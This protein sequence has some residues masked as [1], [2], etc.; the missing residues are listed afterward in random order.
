DVE[1]EDAQMRHEGDGEE[2]Q[3]KEEVEGLRAEATGKRELEADAVDVADGCQSTTEPREPAAD[4]TDHPVAQRVQQLL[5]ADVLDLVAAQLAQR[6]PDGG[7]LLRL[8]H[9][10]VHGQKDGQENGEDR[11]QQHQMSISIVFFIQ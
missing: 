2:P 5:V 10:G 8:A 6:L 9:E 3:G 4:W 11:E 7:L 1:E